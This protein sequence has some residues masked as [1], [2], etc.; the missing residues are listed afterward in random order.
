M[1]IKFEEGLKRLEEI[2]AKLESG[3]ASLEE[4]ISLYEE[5][6]KLARAL[7]S[8]LEEIEMRVE[9]LMETE[10]GFKTEEFRHRTEADE[11]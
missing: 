3:E 7:K 2:V 10:G 11:D 4:A 6:I 5:G 1:E 9:K 8:K